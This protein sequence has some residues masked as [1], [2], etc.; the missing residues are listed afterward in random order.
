MGERQ[1]RQW[2]YY[3]E[4]PVVIVLS[5][6][7]AEHLVSPYGELSTYNYYD[8]FDRALADLHYRDYRG[9]VVEGTVHV[10]TRLCEPLTGEEYAVRH[11]VVTASALAPLYAYRAARAIPLH[12]KVVLLDTYSKREKTLEVRAVLRAAPAH[13]PVTII[14]EN[15]FAVRKVVEY[16]G[17]KYVSYYSFSLISRVRDLFLPEPDTVFEMLRPK[18][19]RVHERALRTKE[20]RKL[21]RLNPYSRT[22]DITS[23]F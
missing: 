16:N 14:A 7:G 12:I 23:F 1:E 2:F 19:T 5:S 20:E 6:S 4:V 18:V 10:V 17:R 9:G 3:V 8:M 13:L 11:E 22:L 21:S 15:P